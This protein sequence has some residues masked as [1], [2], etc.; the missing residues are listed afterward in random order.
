[1]GALKT[2]EVVFEVGKGFPYYGCPLH[3]LR[4]ASRFAGAAEGDAR[5]LGAFVRIAVEPAGD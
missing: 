4:L 1:V 5:P 3:R 2:E